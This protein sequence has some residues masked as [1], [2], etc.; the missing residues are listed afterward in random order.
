MPRRIGMP[1]SELRNVASIALDNDFYGGKRRNFE[2]SLCGKKVEL[3]AY[4]YERSHEL[5]EGAL[6]LKLGKTVLY[7][8]EFEKRSS[9]LTFEAAVQYLE[10][11]YPHGE[12]LPYGVSRSHGTRY[13]T[14]PQNYAMWYIRHLP[15]GSFHD[16]WEDV[17]REYHDGKKMLRDLDYILY[18]V[19]PSG[20]S[21]IKSRDPILRRKCFERI[22]DEYGETYTPKK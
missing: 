8:G 18:A 3:Y 5:F 10:R 19:G 12:L 11:Q 6:V 4:T 2:F 16:N 22:A 17:T 20:V 13:W 14:P 15:I 21:D 9:F 1:I 7:H